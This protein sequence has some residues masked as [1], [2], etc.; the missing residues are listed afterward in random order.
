V[1]I[2]P[3]LLTREKD[4]VDVS[5]S[6]GVDALLGALAVRHRVRLAAVLRVDHPRTHRNAVFLGDV[7]SQARAQAVQGGQTAHG[8]GEIDALARNVFHGANICFPRMEGEKKDVVNYLLRSLAPTFSVLVEMHFVAPLGQVAR[9][10]R[11]HLRDRSISVVGVP[12][13]LLAPHQSPP[14]DG[15]PLRFHGQGENGG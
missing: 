3:L 8:H 4:L 11:A 13:S 2:P 10:Q 9:A 5:P 15:H 6:H 12:L 1:P 7:R 14:D